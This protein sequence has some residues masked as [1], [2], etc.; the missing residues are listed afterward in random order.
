MY[1]TLTGSQPMYE[2]DNVTF[3]SYREGLQ[4]AY[5]REVGNYYEAYR[6]SYLRSQYSPF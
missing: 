1:I 5:E 6:Q 4:K 2:V 3:N